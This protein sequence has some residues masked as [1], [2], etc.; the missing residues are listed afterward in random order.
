MDKQNLTKVESKAVA[1]FDDWKKE[2][3]P[4]HRCTCNGRSEWLETSRETVGWEQK[5][6]NVYVNDPNKT[7]LV[8]RKVTCPECKGSGW[9]KN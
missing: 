4:Y 3:A 2:K 6:F 7:K 8:T 9:V 5:S 1:Y